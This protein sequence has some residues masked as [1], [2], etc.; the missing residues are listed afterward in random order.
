MLLLL[1]L[2]IASEQRTDQRPLQAG[3]V[4]VRLY[5]LAVA[6]EQRTEQ[7][8]AETAARI[9]GVVV[10]AEHG[11]HESGKKGAGT[12]G[13]ASAEKRAEKARCSAGLLIVVFAEQGKKE[14]RDQ[15]DDQG[16]FVQ[17]QTRAFCDLLLN[18]L[19][20]IAQN[21]RHDLFAVFRVGIVQEVLDV[22]GII[23]RMIG[24][25]LF[26]RIEPLLSG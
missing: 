15:C 10:S 4:A 14:R 6:A 20:L 19:I 12:A 2:L 11:A 18:L 21:V 9:A 8:A 24:Q 23:D 25:R 1:R 16:R 26:K 17:R 5:R 22:T 13:V 7:G 3:T